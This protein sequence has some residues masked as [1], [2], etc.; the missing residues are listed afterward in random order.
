VSSYWSPEIF[1]QNLLKIHFIICTSS[2]IRLVPLVDDCQSTYLTDFLNYFLQKKQKTL[3]LTAHFHT[4]TYSNIHVFAPQISPSPTHPK[5]TLET[6]HR[7]HGS[8]LCCYSILLHLPVHA[9][10][11]R[12][13]NLNW[14]NIWFHLGNQ[15]YKKLGLIYID[16]QIG[17]KNR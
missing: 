7:H 4:A 8:H 14:V 3:F 17:K 1:S 15:F 16:R 11:Y 6:E 10:K 9:F 13:M 2:Q 5:Y 12:W